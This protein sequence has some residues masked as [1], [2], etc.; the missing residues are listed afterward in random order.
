M[1]FL[2]FSRVIGSRFY[3]ERVENTRPTKPNIRLRLPQHLP[4]L[5]LPR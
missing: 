3:P 5:Y 4:A 2:N 1:R